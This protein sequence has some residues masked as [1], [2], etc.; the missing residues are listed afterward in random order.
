[1]LII[2]LD[3]LRLHSEVEEIDIPLKNLVIVSLML[4]KSQD[5]QPNV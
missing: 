5:E 4:L 2:I 1:M 3:G